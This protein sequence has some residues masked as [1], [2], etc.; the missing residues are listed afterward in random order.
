MQ[1]NKLVI[2]L[3]GGVGSGKSTVANLFH[4]LG[5]TI[6]DTDKLARDVVQPDSKA[7]H[8]IIQKFGD[9]VMAD[10]Q[11]LNRKALR[12][13]IFSDANAR[14][15][16]EKLL[17]PLIRQEAARQVAA[18]KPPYCIVVIPLLFETERYPF[19]NRI[20]V[21]DTTEALQITRATQRDHESAA[22]VQA[23]LAVQV[24]RKTRLAGADDTIHNEHELADLIPQVEKLHKFYLSLV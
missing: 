10:T 21:V 12:E 5:V 2:G 13:I 9:A 14:T 11:Q 20:L 23:I 4:N 24:D 3:T 6:I 8:A 7:Y 15:W 16:L 22:Q 17:H 18:A 1:S 19:I